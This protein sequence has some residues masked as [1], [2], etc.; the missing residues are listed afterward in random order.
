MSTTRWPIGTLILAAT[1]LA[2]NAAW[3]TE[4]PPPVVPEPTAM[5]LFAVGAAAVAVG[6][7]LRKNR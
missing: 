7:R 1:S 3:A 2:P 6:L 5:A 4:T